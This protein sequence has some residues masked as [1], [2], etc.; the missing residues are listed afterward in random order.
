MYVG[1]DLDT[2]TF[3]GDA[4]AL[5]WAR[6]AM[7]QLPTEFIVADTQ[8]MTRLPGE[9]YDLIHVDGQQDGDGTFHDLKL[10]LAQAR[11]ILVDG[12]FAQKRISWPRP[13]SS[14]SSGI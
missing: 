11:H 9:V 2:S 1:I 6:Q 10:P 3:R 5:R 14:R 13:V 12:Y 8:Q 7:R 4:G